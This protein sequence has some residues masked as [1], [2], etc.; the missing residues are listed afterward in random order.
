MGTSQP[1]PPPNAARAHTK[2][3]RLLC[4]YFTCLPF[5]SFHS[6]QQATA[7]PF[8]SFFFFISSFFCDENLPRGVIHFTRRHQTA[9]LSILST[10]FSLFA[11]TGRRTAAFPCSFSSQIF[12]CEYSQLHCLLSRL[13]GRQ[14]IFS[15][16][17]NKA[18]LV[19]Y[20]KVGDRSLSQPA[21]FV[22]CAPKHEHKHRH[23]IMYRVRLSIY[24]L[25]SSDPISFT[26]YCRLPLVGNIVLWEM[27][28]TLDV[29]VGFE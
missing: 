2:P 10:I 22:S 20:A 12:A 17:Q 21:S 6:S 3:P 25:V 8:F 14:C 23:K 5:H 29:D 15:P 19:R 16:P 9:L 13:V 4:N 27:G 1:R 24:C 26:S 18:S 7:S 28:E 11:S